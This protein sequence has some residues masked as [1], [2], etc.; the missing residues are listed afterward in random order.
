M[1]NR[2]ALP[3]LAR[4][5]A[6]G[7]C[8]SREE[9][10]DAVGAL[11]SESLSDS[12][13]ADFLLVFSKKGETPEEIAHFVEEILKYARPIDFGD[14]S[15]AVLDVCGTGGDRLDLFNIST[16]SMFILSAGGARV[17]KHGN[18]GVTSRSGGADVLEALG[19]RID[20]EPLELKECFL[21][22]GLAFVFAQKYH[23]AFKS[24][25]PVRKM[26]AQRGIATIFN[27]IGPLLNP[28]NLTYQLV[29][30]FSETLLEQYA[31]VLK[32][33]KRKAAWIVHGY[34]ETGLGVDELSTMG[35]TQI[36]ELKNGNIARWQLDPVSLPLSKATVAQLKGG[37][38]TENAKFIQGILSGEI[39]GPKREIVMLNAAA[40]FAVTGLAKNLEEGL[41]QAEAALNSG[42]ALGK[43]NALR[44]FALPA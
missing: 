11:L 44:K 9:V 41:D 4:S 31:Q 37:T 13:K 8:M 23:P 36:C 28:A 1:L 38:P 25:A 21:Q 10:T 42:A 30:V 40:G 20:L 22:H 19:V 29:G 12:E 3:D 32:Q 5:I 16:T 18:R 34:T 33:L 6:N 26:L 2:H 15:G 14:V 7:H 39:T 35:L 24:V 43:L 17:L 27:K